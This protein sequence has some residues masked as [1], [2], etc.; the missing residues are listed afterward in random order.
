MI[1]KVRNALAFCWILSS[2]LPSCQTCLLIFARPVKK[3]KNRP[4]YH[5]SKLLEIIHQSNT[6]CLLQL[7]DS[8]K[9]WKCIKMW[10]FQKQNKGRWI[11]IEHVWCFIKRLTDHI[12]LTSKIHSE[13]KL[14]SLE[15]KNIMCTCVG[16]NSHT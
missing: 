1:V 9:K 15:F 8:Y 10:F 12:L 2:G 3:E 7:T 4:T 16:T 13:L 6:L 14:N 11:V 5:M